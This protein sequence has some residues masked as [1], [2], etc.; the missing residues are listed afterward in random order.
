MIVAFILLT[1]GWGWLSYKYNQLRQAT[2][3]TCEEKEHQEETE[4]VMEFKTAWS[5]CEEEIKRYVDQSR[6]AVCLETIDEWQENADKEM[7]HCDH[8]GDLLMEC[9][10]AVAWM[11]RN[12]HPAHIPT[13]NEK[14]CTGYRCWADRPVPGDDNG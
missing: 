12:W 1:A 5:D 14:N 13:H 10:S 2:P 7:A 3:V 8:V 4:R 9:E 6:Y 11:K